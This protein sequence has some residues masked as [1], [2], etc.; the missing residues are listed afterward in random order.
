MQ[1]DIPLQLPRSPLADE[2]LFARDQVAAVR[3]LVL[4][5][6]G[7]FES[8]LEQGC[9]PLEINRA[10]SDSIDS[11]VC[12]L[13]RN[14]AL[15]SGVKSALVAL[16]GYG[17]R[18]MALLSDVDLLFLM[19]GGFQDEANPLADAILYP[20]WDSGVNVGG[21]TRTVA[22]CRD[23]MTT[24]VRAL[25]AMLD[26]RLVAGSSELYD[27]FKQLICEYFSNA[28]Q[29]KKFITLKIREHE[30]RLQ[31]F[32][33]SIY[34]AQPNVKE[35][36]GGLREYHTLMWCARAA[37]PGD[38]PAAVLARYLRDEV[39]VRRMNASYGFLW[40]VRQALH[41]AE[42][43]WNDRLAEGVQ[44][45][46]ARRLSIRRQGG[47]GDA[48]RLMSLY[49]SNAE[50][51]H[52]ACERGLE[53]IR[54]EVE[55]SSIFSSIIL[56]RRL[57]GGFV[58]TENGTLLMDAVAGEFS[59]DVVMKLFATARRTGLPV[60]PETKAA[61]TANG[62]WRTGLKQGEALSE[63]RSIF[64]EISHLDRVL[65]EMHEC[66]ALEG[67][68]P[69]ME[70]LFHAAQRDGVHLYTV[71]V[72]SIK[73]V[74]E[75]AALV[76]GA[77]RPSHKRALAQIRRPH[78]LALAAFLHDIGKGRGGDHAGKG[79]V[80]AHEIAKGLGLDAADCQDI[81]FLVRSHL[82]M[83]T[84]A[85][86]RDIN[87]PALIERFAQSV[88][89]AE[90]LAMLYLITY[91]DLR[92]VGPSVWSEWKGGLLD[93]LY[94]LT[95]EHMAAG[96]AAPEKRAR[97][98]ERIIRSVLRRIGAGCEEE[99]VREFL[100]TLP[101]RYL[102]SVDP[103]SV[104]AHFMMSRDVGERACAT[105]TREVSEKGCTEF[106]VVTPDSPGL[107]AKIAG[108]LSAN[109][110]NIV[111]AQLYTS[112]HG[113]AIDVLWVTDSLHRPMNDPERWSRIRSELV[114]AVS[115]ERE[116]KK[117]VGGRFKQR[118]LAWNAARRPVEVLVDNDVSALHTVVE[119]S[120]DDRRGLL[121]TI[122]DTIH[123]LGL[124]IDLARITT[125][126]DRVTDVFYIKEASGKKVEAQERLDGI[127]RAL[128]DALAE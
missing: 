111:T 95:Q 54:R 81:E 89:S 75:I 88:R 43:S 40:S 53:M 102:F 72:H 84:L 64:S 60:D 27:G 62:G 118:L 126:V 47:E 55:P 4:E 44:E 49:Y 58:K 110:A 115:G 68:F 114:E 127:R 128:S 42:G 124:M 80:I 107:F 65:V 94:G 120:A 122:A 91:A 70:E 17:R 25:T 2:P 16:G 5:R 26:A 22:D 48:Q 21:A 59:P 79:A 76:A 38:D 108:V 83:A 119:I 86:K 23:V 41:L 85:F 82:L 35:G 87:D 32:G 50:Q 7:W 9:A 36:E 101:E 37:R 96:G 98:S 100:E 106:S 90:L 28:R 8:A 20:F 66:G 74:G 18:E 78:V 63:A 51:L 117:I 29:R 93:D 104:A 56:R 10:S 15:Q 116:L 73:T 11:A 69:E 34:L 13:F 57:P 77:K 61:L 109:G 14:A 12:L 67:A 46:V 103:E 33:S 105:I 121:Y 112:A 31:R 99:R 1:K 39:A 30:K 52:L 6:R 45:E 3:A 125:H 19:E 71:G 113:M 123:E 92:A 24:D 97:E